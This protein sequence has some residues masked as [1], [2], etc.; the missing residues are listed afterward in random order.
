MASQPGAIDESPNVT[1][2]PTLSASRRSGIGHASYGCSRHYAV[3][4]ES[5]EQSAPALQYPPGLRPRQRGPFLRVRMHRMNVQME[6]F[7]VDGR[8]PRDERMRKARLD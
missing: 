1:I 2:R 6:A 5:I 8:D 7:A 3:V 4:L